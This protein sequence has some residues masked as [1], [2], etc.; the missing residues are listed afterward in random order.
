MLFLGMRTLKNIDGGPEEK[1]QG[2][3]RCPYQTPKGLLGPG[4]HLYGGYLIPNSG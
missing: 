3:V 1:N 2:V 4:Y